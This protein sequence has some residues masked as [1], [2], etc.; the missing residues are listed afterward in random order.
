VLSKFRESRDLSEL[1]ENVRKRRK[2]LKMSQ[3]R[4]AELAQLSDNTVQRLESVCTQTSVETLFQIAKAL[5]VTPNDLAPE[6][7]GFPKSECELAN[8]SYQFNQL[9]EE[10]KKIVIQSVGALISGFLH[11]Q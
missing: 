11:S 9:N 8:F 7:Y 10:N 2:E 6:H 4:L 1:S 3:T 5:G